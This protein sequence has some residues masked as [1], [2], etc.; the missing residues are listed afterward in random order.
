VAAEEPLGNRLG[1][2]GAVL[3]GGAG[4]RIGGDK[5]AVG[6]EGQPLV[7]WVIDA[8]TPVT[9]SVAVVAKTETLLPQ[10]DPHVSLWLE[11]DAEFHPLLGIVHALTCA[12]GQAVLV[13]AA[14]MPLIT[15]AVLACLAQ[16]PAA[17]SNGRIASVDGRLQPLCASYEPQALTKLRDFDRDARATDTV[18]ALGVE[19]VEFDDPLPF[20]NVNAPEDLLT[21][22]AELKKRL[23]AD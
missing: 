4:R 17:G 21:A 15:P 5:A 18:L 8:V 23:S 2:V 12:R 9:D 3:A 13:V 1:T 16:Q 7:Q 10:I 19:I 22:G 20:F 11:T 14:D 6:L